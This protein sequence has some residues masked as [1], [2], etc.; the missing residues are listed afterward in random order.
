VELARARRFGAPRAL[1]V[2]LAADGTVCG[3]GEGERLLREAVMVLEG[4]IARLELARA[5]MELGAL[6]RRSNRRAEARDPLRRALDIAQ[7]LGASAVADRAREELVAAGGRPRRRA[8]SGV[9]A[10]TPQERRV[11]DMAATAMTNKEV[12]QALFVTEGTVEAHLG[13]AYA[14]LGIG[15]RSELGAALGRHADL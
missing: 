2:A 4:S 8:L 13:R 10:L 1:G 11:A 12:A 3:A 7:R 5:L 15:S 9:E 14:K 6:L